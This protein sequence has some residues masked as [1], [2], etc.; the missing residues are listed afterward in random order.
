MVFSGVNF[1]L[2]YSIYKGKIRDVFYNEELRLYLGIIFASTVA[3][4]INLFMTS[5][6][7]MG[8]AFR[9]SFFFK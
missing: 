2:Y 9:D 3:I 4:G 8:L 6:N 7:N 1:S 5:Y